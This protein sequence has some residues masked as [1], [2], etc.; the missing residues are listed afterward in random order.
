MSALR[1]RSNASNVREKLAANS[2]TQTDLSSDVA[3]Q[4]QRLERSNQLE[5]RCLTWATECQLTKLI[6]FQFGV[7]CLFIWMIEAKWDGE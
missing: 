2:I 7:L 4:L 1:K 3:L 5:V 6:C